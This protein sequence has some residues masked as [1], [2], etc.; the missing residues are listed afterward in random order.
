MSPRLTAWM[1]ALRPQ[2]PLRSPRQ[3]L[4]ELALW[5]A[6]GKLKKK[7]KQTNFSLDQYMPVNLSIK[8][9]G[10]RWVNA[11]EYISAT[12]DPRPR[13]A[14][15]TRILRNSDRGRPRVARWVRISAWQGITCAPLKTFGSFAR[16]GKI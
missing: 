3:A 1:G 11:F 14:L 10:A 12:A 16:D 9:Q 7:S 13:A 15:T 2:N 4:G 6:C 8:I 5:L